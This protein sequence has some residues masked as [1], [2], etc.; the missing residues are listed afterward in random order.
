MELLSSLTGLGGS[1]RLGRMTFADKR[2]LVVHCG[3]RVL[4]VAAEP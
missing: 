3:R 4:R 1:G 2:N